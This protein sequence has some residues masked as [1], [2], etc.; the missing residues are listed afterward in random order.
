M[1]SLYTEPLNQLQ[2]HLLAFSLTGTCRNS[3]VDGV[4]E[5]VDTAVAHRQPVGGKN[6]Q[7]E[8]YIY[9]SIL[10]CICITYI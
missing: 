6:T 3:P 8:Q 5:R 9:L 7:V 10:R 4:D 1:Y 2:F